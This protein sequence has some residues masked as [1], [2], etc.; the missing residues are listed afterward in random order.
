MPGRAPVAL[1]A[2]LGRM[3]SRLSSCAGRTSGTMVVT[4]LHVIG[5]RLAPLLHRLVERWSREKG[6]DGWLFAHRLRDVLS[7]CPFACDDGR[8]LVASRP[9]D[10]AHGGARWAL[11]V[12][13]AAASFCGGGA[14]GR[15][16]LQR[17]SGD[18]VTAD[19][20]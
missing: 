10:C 2:R 7:G 8:R 16:P 17:S 1:V 4:A 13:A 18:V 12:R 5:R 9:R 11:V 15:P 3:M 19:F 14:A 20:F 6:D